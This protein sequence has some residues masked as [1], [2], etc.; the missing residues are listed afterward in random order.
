MADPVIYQTATASN[1]NSVTA[2]ERGCKQLVRL[3]KKLTAIFRKLKLLC[4]YPYPPIKRK[5]EVS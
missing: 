4:S 5:T 2:F 1:P 3:A